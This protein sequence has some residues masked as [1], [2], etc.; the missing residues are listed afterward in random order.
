MIRSFGD[1]ETEKIYQQ[2]KSK[3]LPLEIQKRA[4][5]KLLLIDAANSEEDLKIP[6][7]NRFEYLSENLKGYCSIRINDQWRIVFRYENCDAY[8]VSISDYH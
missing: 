7:G 3:K 2:I 8:D 4:L 6:P 1:A 5:V